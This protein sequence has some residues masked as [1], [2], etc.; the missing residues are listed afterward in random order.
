MY[1]LI[2]LVQMLRLAILTISFLFLG[3][4]NWS[5]MNDDTFTPVYFNS[6]LTV[7]FTDADERANAISVCN[8]GASTDETPED[9]REC[10]FDILV[11]LT[12]IENIEMTTLLTYNAMNESANSWQQM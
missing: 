10:Y 4:G 3:F 1:I 7:M 2:S 11:R 9:R 12:E 8:G 5:S 6:N